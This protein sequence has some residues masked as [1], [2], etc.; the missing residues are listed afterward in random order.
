MWHF[1]YYNLYG[2]FCNAPFW[3]L[4]VLRCTHG[5]FSGPCKRPELGPTVNPWRAPSCLHGQVSAPRHGKRPLQWWPSRLP[6]LPCLEIRM[7]CA[8]SF[9]FVKSVAPTVHLAS[10][11]GPLVPSQP[12]PL[13]GS[14]CPSLAGLISI[15]YPEAQK[16]GVGRRWV[17]TK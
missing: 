17:P 3:W 12:V 15:N 13:L 5:S 2:N 16:A 1:G 7:C 11:R 4:L 8:I 9:C 6:S 14:H 10:P